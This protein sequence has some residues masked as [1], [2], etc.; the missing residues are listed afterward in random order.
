[1]ING[2]QTVPLTI[3]IILNVLKLNYVLYVKFTVT[4]LH[5]AQPQFV[6]NAN[7]P[8]TLNLFVLNMLALIAKNLDT[9]CK[10]ALKSSVLS[11]NNMVIYKLIV[12]TSSA[13]IA[14]KS[15]INNPTVLKIFAINVNKSVIFLKIVPHIMPLRIKKMI[16]YPPNKKMIK[17]PRNKM[18]IN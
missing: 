4:L 3:I 13:K 14:T 9:L 5:T 10:N 11:V 17:Y 8:V 2:V 16:N 1:M 18:V 12:L 15:V 7:K 6:C